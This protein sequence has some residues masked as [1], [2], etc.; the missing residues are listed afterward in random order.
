MNG[1]G[2]P[3]AQPS[4]FER[5]LLRILA[6][7]RLG[8][9]LALAGMLLCASAL[10]MGFYLDDYVGRYIYSDRPGAHWLFEQYVGGYGLA[11]G[12]PA[13]IHRQ[14]ELGWAPWWTYD[15][16][17]IRLYRPFGVWFHRL[18][19]T[20]WPQSAFAMHLHS[21]LWLG[22]LVLVTTHMFR[23]ALGPWI[24]A[25]A[26]LMFALDQ[27]HGFEVGY[28]CNRHALI[29]AVLG[30]L[31]LD[32]HLT[33]FARRSRSHQLLAY[34][35]YAVALTSGES[36]IAILGYLFAHALCVERAPL[37]RR[38]LRFAPYLLITVVWRVLYTRAGY[39]G[40]GSGLYID[41]GHE[42]GLYLIKLLE[43]A[44]VLLLGQFLAPPGEIYAFASPFWSR[45]ILACAWLF[46]IALLVALWA[47][48]R[49]KRTAWFWLLGALGSL[50]PAASTY[51]HDRQL[52]FTSFGAMALLAQM[53]ELFAIELR[54]Q[55]LGKLER[56]AREWSGLL[57]FT[58]LFI[59]PLA[60]PFTTLGI[61]ATAPLLQ[62]PASIHDDI[63]GH[64]AVFV[65]APDYF[66]VKLVQFE[67]YI[68]RRPQPR[69][70]RALG[71]GPERTTVYR[72][73]PNTLELAYEGGI[74][75]SPFMELYRDRRI[76]M[77][78]GERVE[79]EGLRIEVTEL[80][81]DQRA[82]RA[83]F[84]FD[85]PLDAERF[86]FYAWLNGHFERLTLPAVGSSR[87]LPPALLELGF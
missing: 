43:R 9:W 79:L 81:P 10:G 75:S 72:T 47:I 73:A 1:A 69:R 54:E 55:S 17:L 49:R 20:L 16:L 62:A 23:T 22:L 6:Q 8:W 60:L 14:I 48:L 80:T 46:T 53:W 70:Y 38:A 86:Q 76:P 27:T 64:D 57:L 3:I 78:I 51:P 77:M 7:P 66:A 44:P 37:V 74:L 65:T 85:A 50:V 59:S 31:C 18:D 24:G 34:L 32:L 30:V 4:K 5:G 33:A 56:F 40:S 42:P 35:A 63:K 82:S 36:T 13:D 12:N 68:D 28:I 29:T 87:Q 52:L 41:P 45:V 71:F 61:A 15:H 39:G 83:R 26:A 25:L 11:N 19:F 21:L 67:R 2:W 84:T 58:R